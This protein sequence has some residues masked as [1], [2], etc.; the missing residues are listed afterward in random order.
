MSIFNSPT[1]GAPEREE[2]ARLWSRKLQQDASGLPQ[3]QRHRN[4]EPPSAE[5]LCA[6]ASGI[7]ATRLVEIGGSSGISTIALAVAA[8]ATGGRLISF[9]IEPMRQQEAQQTIASLGL[10]RHVEF[11][12]EDAGR[13]LSSIGPLDFVLIDCE[14]EDYIRFFDLLPLKPGAIVVAD[15]VISHGLTDYVRHVRSRPGVESIT[16]PIGK[17]LEVSR[18]TDTSVLH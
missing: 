15:N 13:A 11:H 4:L 16:L 18:Q 7:G 3:T 6:L 14:K 2:I 12:L 9:E 17:G 8:R 10:S 5:F 1:L